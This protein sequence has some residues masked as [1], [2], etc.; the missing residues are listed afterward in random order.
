M[1]ET[2]LVTGGAGYIGSHAC[3]ALATAGYRPVALDNLSTGWRD[4]VKFGPLVQA[5][6][7]DRAALA[8]AFAER[9]GIV[10]FMIAVA[11]I[12]AG[13]ALAVRLTQLY[14]GLC[15]VVEQYRPLSAAVEETFVNKN[16]ASTLKLGQA[17][18]I[19]LLVPANGG[20]KV[21]EYSPNLIK[22]T[23]VGGGHAAKQQIQMM[24]KTL[25]PGAELKSADAADALA[26]AICHAH[27]RDSVQIRAAMNMTAMT[28]GEASR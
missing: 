21:F 1:P 24:V 27:H 16:A 15:A 17:R 9:F 25:L 13:A 3:K 26:V 19:S 5:D 10:P 12:V 4:A 23:V 22:K 28:A 2:V 8:A 20:L 14:E 11:V 18:A 7:M 6:L